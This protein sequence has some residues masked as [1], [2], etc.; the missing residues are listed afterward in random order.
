MLTLNGKINLTLA[1]IAAL[2]A[3]VK[4]QSDAIASLQLAPTST[5][6]SDAI[7]E[8]QAKQAV[9]D[10]HLTTID[11]EIGTEADDAPVAA[12]VTPA[13]PVADTVPAATGADTVTGVTA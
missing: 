10:T 1:A 4:A 11:G 12:P 9:V 2:G 5:T 6:T 8:L 13:T 7:A 3:T